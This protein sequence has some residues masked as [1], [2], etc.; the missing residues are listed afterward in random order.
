MNQELRVFCS[1]LHV[2]DDVDDQHPQKR[3]DDVENCVQPQAIDLHIPEVLSVN[4]PEEIV[5]GIA[6]SY[7]NEVPRK[8]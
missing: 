6:R 4:V 5:R 8:V 1:G 3:R 7:L 2:H